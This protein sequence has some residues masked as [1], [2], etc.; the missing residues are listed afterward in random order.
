M[1]GR[2]DIGYRSPRSYPLEDQLVLRSDTHE[3]ILPPARFFFAAKTIF[4]FGLP[5]P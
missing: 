1:H 2:T 4:F 5:R 3:S